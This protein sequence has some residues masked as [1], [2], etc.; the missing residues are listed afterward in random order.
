MASTRDEKLRR[1]AVQL[2]KIKVCMKG[3]PPKPLPLPPVQDSPKTAAVS[4]GAPISSVPPSKLEVSEKS[5]QSPYCHRN[6]KVMEIVSML[7]SSATHGDSEVPDGPT[8][9]AKPQN[10]HV[11]PAFVP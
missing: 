8:K 9:L 2:E 11:L 1:L 7:R 3:D 10:E 5:D 6:P 4:K